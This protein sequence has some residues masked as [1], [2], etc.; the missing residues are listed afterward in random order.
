MSSIRL[1]SKGSFENTKRLLDAIRK[2]KR[3]EDVLKRYAQ[4]GVDELEKATPVDS[5]VTAN[6]WRCDIS[7]DSD[8]YVLTWSN[9]NTTSTGI[10]IVVLLHYGHGTGTGGY[11]QGRDFINPVMQPIFDRLSEELYKEVI[12]E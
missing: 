5:G 4:M 2:P 10:P 12:G 9:D 11:V 3:I 1:I 6:S 8:G 7:T